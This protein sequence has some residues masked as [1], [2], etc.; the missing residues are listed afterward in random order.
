[1]LADDTVVATVMSNSGFFR[2][3]ERAGMKCVQTAVGDRFVYERMQKDGYSIGGEQSGHIILRKYATTGDGILTAIMLTEEV[4][5]RKTPLAELAAPVTLYPQY[6]VN[7]KVKD[8]DAVMTDRCV[9]EA[10]TRVNALIGGNGRVLLRK[11]GTEPV[12]RVMTEAE[13]LG[14][15]KEYANIV[16]D[17]IK[18][19][20]YG[21]E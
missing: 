5:D 15:C 11:S 13:A 9:T 16:A 1:M 17:A 18:A 6:T 14:K 4:C 10:I 2:S 8:K 3:L 19:G 21:I 7:I 12:I 20:G